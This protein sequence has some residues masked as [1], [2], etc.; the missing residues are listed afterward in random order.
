MV[1][2]LSSLGV[3][4]VGMENNVCSHGKGLGAAPLVVESNSE[5]MNRELGTKFNK[6]L[7]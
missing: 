5:P 3:I 2:P 7:P 6:I 4:A 1:L